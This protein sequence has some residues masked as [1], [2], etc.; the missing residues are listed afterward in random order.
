M[1]AV[2]LIQDVRREVVV[3]P[4]PVPF[5]LPGVSDLTPI[6]KAVGQLHVDGNPIPITKIDILNPRKGMPAVVFCTTDKTITLFFRAHQASWAKKLAEGVCAQTRP[7]MMQYSESEF[8]PEAGFAENVDR[9]A[10]MRMYSRNPSLRPSK[11]MLR[12]VKAAFTGERRMIPESFGRGGQIKLSSRQ[13]DLELFFTKYLHFTSEQT[14]SILDRI[15]FHSEK[16]KAEAKETTPL[17]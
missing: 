7:G 11:E 14:K 4:I 10:D 3:S 12:L 17:L 8:I 6:A 16:E 15:S 1:S 13:E 2:P 5:S 9:E